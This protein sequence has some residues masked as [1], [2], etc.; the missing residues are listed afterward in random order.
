MFGKT[1]KAFGMTL[2][3][4]GLLLLV[5][6]LLQ[7]AV[8][9]WFSRL[10]MP[11]LL[12][13]ATAGVAHAEGPFSGALC[14]LFAGMLT[15]SAMGKPLIAFTL[16]LPLL[17]FLLGWLAETLLTRNFLAY[18]AC[19]AG[20]TLA[21]SAYQL[22]SPLFFSHAPLHALLGT[23]LL[24]LLLSMAAAAILYPFIRRQLRLKKRI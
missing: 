19:C 5:L 8:L 10:A 22:I 20:A 16:L 13:V 17:G 7:T 14:G 24:Q 2:L 1:K 21:C 4:H 3:R 11:L 15:D 12:V 23:L 18:L 6:Y 9:P